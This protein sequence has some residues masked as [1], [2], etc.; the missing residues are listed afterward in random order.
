[1]QH[2]ETT[3]IHLTPNQ[4]SWTGHPS[5]CLLGRGQPKGEPL[6]QLRKG[7][8]RRNRPTRQ[9]IPATTYEVVRGHVDPDHRLGRR[10][11]GRLASLAEFRGQDAPVWT[12]LAGFSV[13]SAET[14]VGRYDDALGHLTEVR[15]LA[16]RSDHSWIASMSL[17]DLGTP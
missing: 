4:R 6:L 10:P 5:G 13:G 15:D 2:P 7:S 16:E 17:V 9:V 8:T 1:M 14:I 3:N 12:A 11:A